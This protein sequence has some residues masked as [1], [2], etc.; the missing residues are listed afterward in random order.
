ME[1]LLPTAAEMDEHM[2]RL[3]PAQVDSPGFQSKDEGFESP[4]GRQ[5]TRWTPKKG[6]ARDI[7]GLIRAKRTVIKILED[8]I[9]IL[10][11][12]LAMTNGG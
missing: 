4:G 10:E 1:Y 5:D 7:L 9:K 3:T 2:Q 12:E 6:R 8:E 11:E